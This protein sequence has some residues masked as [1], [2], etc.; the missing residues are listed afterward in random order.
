LGAARSDGARA[1]LMALKG[2]RVTFFSE[3]EGNRF[4]EEM[5][6]SHTGG[7]VISARALY[8]NDIVSWEPTHSITFLT[9]EAPDV[10]DLGPSMASRVMVADFRERFDGEKQDRKLPDKLGEEA[11]GVLAILCWAA[12]AWY[13]AWNESGEGI[14][15]PKRVTDQSRAFMER[16]D[17]VAAVIN[18]AF[19]IEM[20]AKTQASRL[21]E[22]YLQWHTRSDRTDE[23]ISQVRFAQAMERKGFKKVKTAS[24]M[25]YLGVKPL[26]AW[27]MADKDNG[28]DDE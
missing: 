1:D 23:P 16:N 12:A 10:D 27:R 20:G 9:N 28:D 6:K 19:E 17:V 7:D 15:L 2:K 3:P 25:V 26:S 14:T 4:N 11:D 21:Y 22:A 8:S 24:G 18:D 5:L 13:G